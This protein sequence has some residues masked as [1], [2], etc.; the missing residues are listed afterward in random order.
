MKAEYKFYEEFDEYKAIKRRY[1]VDTS[2]YSLKKLDL[3]RLSWQ[4]GLSKDSKQTYPL[5]LREWKMSFIE[6]FI[7]EDITNNI[8]KFKNLDKLETT[9]KGAVAYFLGMVFTYAYMYKN[10]NLKHLLHLNNEEIIVGRVNESSPDLW[11]YVDKNQS[12][13][14]EAKGSL[15]NAERFEKFEDLKNAYTQLKPVYGIKLNYEQRQKNGLVKIKSWNFSFKKLKKMIIGTHPNK[16][17]NVR[18]EAIDPTSGDKTLIEIDGDK[19][20]H[21]YYSNIMTFLVQNKDFAQIE[22]VQGM[23]FLV[24]YSTRFPYRIGL[25]KSLYDI[26]ENKFHFRSSPDLSGLFKEINKRLEGLDPN[27]F[28]NDDNISLGNDGIIFMNKIE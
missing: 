12:Y 19:A 28:E 26:L 10:C 8:L 6:A 17:F 5:E 27:S 15:I 14:V 7:E 2:T 23:E 21:N 9:E 4:V 1:Q 22:R 20:I 25:F 24:I 11:G 3:M 18:H 13:L 16:D